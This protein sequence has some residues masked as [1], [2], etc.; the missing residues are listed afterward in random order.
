LFKL[1][2]DSLHSESQTSIYIQWRFVLRNLSSH[3]KSAELGVNAC[4]LLVGKPEGKKPLGRPRRR[5]VDTIKMD[6]GEIGWGGVD[7]IGLARDRDKWRAL[8]NSVMNLRVP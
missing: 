4:R 7:W 5:W 6:L 3:K 1:P 2:A 8:V